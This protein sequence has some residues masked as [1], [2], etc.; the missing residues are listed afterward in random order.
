[1]AQ[2]DLLWMG[3]QNKCQAGLDRTSHIPSEMIL[4]YFI[5]QFMYENVIIIL[6]YQDLGK[7]NVP[8]YWS[9]ILSYVAHTN[10]DMA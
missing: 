8:G 6:I 1:M 2:S 10:A 9:Q 5:M 7:N 4:G 3:Y